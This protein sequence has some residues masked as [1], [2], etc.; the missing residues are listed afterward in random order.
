[1]NQVFPVAAKQNV[2]SCDSYTATN[3]RSWS[4][5]GTDHS[6]QH[7]VFLKMPTYYEVAAGMPSY[8]TPR[9]PKALIAL[10]R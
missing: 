6:R 5:P 1:M 3:S 8:V 4:L 9:L 10:F 7:R 2:P